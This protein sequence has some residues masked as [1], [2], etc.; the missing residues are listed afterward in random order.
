MLEDI[1]FYWRLQVIQTDQGVSID[2][3]SDEQEEGK[4]EIWKM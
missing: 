4:I 2:N 1:R 3:E